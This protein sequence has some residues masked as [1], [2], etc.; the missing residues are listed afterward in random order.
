MEWA[1]LELTPCMRSP[2]RSLTT[3]RT[4]TSLILIWKTSS[5]VHFPK[6]PFWHLGSILSPSEKKK[7]TCINVTSVAPWQ[8]LE[9]IQ[10]N[11]SWMWL[12]HLVR[13]LWCRVTSLWWGALR[14]SWVSAPASGWMWVLLPT[15]KGIHGLRTWIWRQTQPR[16]ILSPSVWKLSSLTFLSLKFPCLW[17]G[18]DQTFFIQFL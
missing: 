6:V 13:H 8:S 2:T 11:V 9:V 4:R 15:Q 14:H 18:D 1:E 17:N 5:R 10:R 16:F 3:G 7:V 12:S